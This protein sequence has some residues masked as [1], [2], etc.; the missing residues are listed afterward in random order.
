MTIILTDKDWFARGGNRL[1]YVHPEDPNQCL[2]IARYL[3]DPSYASSRRRLPLDEN[4]LEAKAFQRLRA[5]LTEAIL[6][7]QFLGMVETDIGKAL[8]CSLFRDDDG[9]ISRTLEYT[10]WTEGMTADLGRALKEFLEGWSRYGFATRKILPHNLVV[11]RSCTKPWQLA[12][13][14]G[15]TVSWW[16]RITLPLFRNAAVNAAEA[17]NAAMAVLSAKQDEDTELAKSIML[18]VA[19]W[20]QKNL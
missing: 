10:L 2:K 4:A 7:P 17:A 19:R 1:C 16:G 5:P 18:R 3:N 12:L 6:I 11:V 20:N 8:A 14:D 13:V 9:K 15:F